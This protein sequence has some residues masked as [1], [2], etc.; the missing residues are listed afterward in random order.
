M[1]K[2]VKSSTDNPWINYGDVNYME[3][4]ALFIRSESG[5]SDTEFEVIYLVEN[6]EDE[7]TIFA[8]YGTVDMSDEWLQKYIVSAPNTMEA[9]EEAFDRFGLSSYLEF[10]LYSFDSDGQTSAWAHYGSP[11]NFLISKS[12]LEPQLHAMGVV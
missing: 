7:N 6:P 10:E 9:V 4:G 11:D 1:Y 3:Y 12:E 5:R 2:Y 8:G